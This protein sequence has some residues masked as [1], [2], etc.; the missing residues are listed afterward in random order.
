M[1][2]KVL[3]CRT[4]LLNREVHIVS[5]K[6]IEI[7]D[8]Y[9]KDGGS[10]QYCNNVIEL[11]AI[12]NDEHYYKVVAS[13]EELSVFTESEGKMITCNTLS[14]SFLQKLTILL[15]NIKSV[16]LSYDGMH[17]EFINI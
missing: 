5:N 3:V 14:I 12:K 1:K 4:S 6:P 2:H 8:F 10:L 11:Q 16:E 17:D 9:V 15:F 13:S 7:G